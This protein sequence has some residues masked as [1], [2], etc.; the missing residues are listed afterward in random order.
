MT[1][2]QRWCLKSLISLVPKE[3]LLIDF[4]CQTV[5]NNKNNDYVF[6]RPMLTY[7]L[8]HCVVQ[9][10]RIANQIFEW[11]LIS[12]LLRSIHFNK[13]VIDHS[14]MVPLGDSEIEIVRISDVFI[15]IFNF[16]HTFRDFP[17]I[18]NLMIEPLEK[19]NLCVSF[20]LW[21]DLLNLVPWSWDIK[22]VKSNNV[23]R[24]LIDRMSY[25]LHY[26]TSLTNLTK[27]T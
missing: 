21:E 18:K 7:Y 4:E 23:S 19:V 27:Y 14:K 15:V 16:P 24:L 5:C 2:L 25:W 12:E 6:R 8:T 1:E 20:W 13:S 3:S 22:Q 17:L 10:L 9:E 11:R 26:L